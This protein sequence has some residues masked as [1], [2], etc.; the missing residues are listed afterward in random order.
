MLIMFNVLAILTAALWLDFKL[1]RRH[2][3]R[4]ARITQALARFQPD[5]AA[6]RED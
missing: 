2:Y 4:Q 3:L 1:E 6:A 5:F